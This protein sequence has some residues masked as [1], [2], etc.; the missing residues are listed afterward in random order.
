ML[1][2]VL[3]GV[4]LVLLLLASL[5]PEASGGDWPCW[6]GPDRTGVS[7]ETGLLA[8]WP[9]EGP[10]LLWKATGLGGG[11]STPSVAAGRVFALGSKGEDEFLLAL[12]AKDGKQ[13]WSTRLGLIG[14]NDGPPHPGPR[15][16]PTVDAGLVY[17]LGSDGDLVCADSATGK[18]IWRKHLGR[19]F[20][21]ER[22][23]WAYGE[24]PL[25]DG[26][27]LVC[28]PG[29]PTATLVG[30]SRK[31]GA[32][33]WKTRGP[34]YNV[35]GYASP[36]IASVGGRKLYVQF[37]GPGVVG[38][39]ARDGSLLWWYRGNV[40]GV[41][42]ATPIFHDGCIF[43]TA[44]GVPPAGGDALLRLVATAK[45]VEVREVY[46][47]RS[48]ANHHGGVVRVGEYVYGTGGA[49]LVC[50]EW[51]TGAVKWQNRSIGRGS[52]TVA[53]GH[54]YLRG[55]RGAMALVEA[56]PDGYREKGRFQQPERSRFATFAHP[57]VAGGRLYLR[58]EDV[59]LCY[60]VQAR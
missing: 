59:L 38:V 27:V 46:K 43:A 28:T 1:S 45:G 4:L 22:G 32:V 17:A 35:A 8:T 49:G 55:E 2:R 25:V 37:L 6:R 44:S 11:Y 20:D 23:T 19:D 15:A 53:D 13:L 42:A 3:L 30:L 36:I 51:K 52:V 9:K 7:T 31:T 29:G 40:G 60:D 48:I 26:D 16:T 56:T 14:V 57:V 24:S 58:D 41:S 12:D 10:R 34:E 50:L 54:I 5:H 21:G 18:V 39:D 33:L 47:V